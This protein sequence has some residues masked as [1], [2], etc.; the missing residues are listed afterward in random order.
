MRKWVLRALVAGA[1]ILVAIQFI[2]Y[3]RSHTNPAVTATPAWDSP[4]TEAL[5]RDACG[6]CHS[7]LTKWPWYTRVAPASWLVYSD[8]K[9]GREHL[10]FS[11]WQRTQDADL[12]EVLDVIRGGDMP[13]VQYRLIHGAARLSSTEKEQL[14]AGL[15]RT[16]A[17]SPPG[18]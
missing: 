17:A 10:N 5:V 6:D 14:A 13:P 12:R 9:G 18:G 11:E 16:W 4:R 3:G 2:P 8:V 1:V 15:A 7:N